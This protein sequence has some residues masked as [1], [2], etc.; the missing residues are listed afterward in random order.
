VNFHARSAGVSENGV[1]SF[2]LKAS[3]KDFA[4]GHAWADLNRLFSRLFS[5]FSCFAHMDFSIFWPAVA[6]I[7]KPTTVA[8]RGCLSKFSL[9]STSPCGFVAYDDD[10]QQLNLPSN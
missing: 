5:G 9:H 1:N 7:K 10:Q 4:A 2:A 8:S 6:D 3:H